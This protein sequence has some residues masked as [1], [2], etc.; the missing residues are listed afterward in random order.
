MFPKSLFANCNRSGIMIMSLPF[1]WQHFILLFVLVFCLFCH[2]PLLG[3]E[4]TGIYIRYCSLGSPNF[5]LH[6]YSYSSFFW[7]LKSHLPTRIEISNKNDR[8][9][10]FTSFVGVIPDS[11]RW[12][13]GWNT[14]RIPLTDRT[15]KH[16]SITD[17]KKLVHF[18][19]YRSGD[20]TLDRSRKADFVSQ[21]LVPFHVKNTP[22]DHFK[23]N[24]HNGSYH[25][26]AA[27]LLCADAGLCTV[28][29]CRVTVEHLGRIYFTRRV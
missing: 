7:G 3:R 11:G 24:H 15:I 19:V 18:Q 1:I 4:L 2:I 21:L 5:T 22:N 10:I 12:R 6:S 27:R 29:S 28:C 16:A 23:D 9:G 8:E 25:D 13:E 14:I 17:W 20:Q 26:T